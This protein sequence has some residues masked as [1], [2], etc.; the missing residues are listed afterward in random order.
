MRNTRWIIGVVV[1]TGHDTKLMKNQ[2]RTP[3]KAS[4]V[5]R[6]T[7]RFIFMI[8][9][10]EIIVCLISTIGIMMWIVCEQWWNTDVIREC[11]QSL[12]GIFSNI[13]M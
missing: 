3:H 6:L 10:L 8:F 1:F 2:S 7:N 9:M 12:L 11:L 13:L 4:R 5:E